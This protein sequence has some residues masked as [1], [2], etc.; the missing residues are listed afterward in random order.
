MS[1]TCTVCAS[2]SRKE[3]DLALLL[4]S[5]GYRDIA[6]RYH[7]DKSA[8]MRHQRAHLKMS[9]ELSKGLGAMLSGDNLLARLGEWHEKMQDQYGRADA[10]GNVLAAV[11]TARAGIA[12]IESFSKIG[13]MADLQRRLEIL[14]NA[15]DQ[16]QGQDEEETAYDASAR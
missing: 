14:E 10:A 7:L 1:R 6:R 12:A 4:H 13:I 3:I 15:R 8:L 11:A 5:A 9:L 16:D 2:P